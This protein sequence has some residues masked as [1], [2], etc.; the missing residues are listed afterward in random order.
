MPE[1][2]RAHLDRYTAPYELVRE[3]GDRRLLLVVDH[4]TNAIPAEMGTLGLSEAS[5]GR[6]IASDLGVAALARELAAAMNAPAILAGF[7]R[8]VIDANRGEDDPTLVMRL[9]DGDVIPGNVAADEAEIARRV[10]LYH[11]PYHTAIDAALDRA[12]AG[13]VRPLLISLHS[14]TPVWR[15]RPRPWHCAILS[16]GD[17]TTADGLLSRLRANRALLVGDNEP[18]SGD[19]EGDCMD[20]HG[21]RRGLPHALIEL[22][23]DL[24]LTHDQRGEWVR[25]LSAILAEMV[26]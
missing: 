11:R 26:G 4:A 6:H 23:Q 24:I 10:R 20:R 9:S 16:S 2:L 18:Y 21:T 15:G 8:L 13:D 19:L 1:E 17:R 22:R 7:S 14:F 3:A 5:L 12:L 25:R